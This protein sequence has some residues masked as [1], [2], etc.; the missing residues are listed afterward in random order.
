MHAIQWM[1]W[2]SVATLAM[3][4]AAAQAPARNASVTTAEVTPNGLR[5]AALLAAQ[6][7]D[8]AQTAPLWASASAATRG[9]VTQQQFVASVAQSRKGYRSAA[10]ARL[11]RYQSA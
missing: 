11:G 7:I 4:E 2:L 1:L 10:A 9:V 3:P 5:D 6:A 8:S